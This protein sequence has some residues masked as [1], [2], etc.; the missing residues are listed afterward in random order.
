[1]K[2]EDALR[3]LLHE[4]FKNLTKEELEELLQSALRVIEKKAKKK[5]A[6]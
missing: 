2:I 5:A 3:K 4:K 1:M 6:S